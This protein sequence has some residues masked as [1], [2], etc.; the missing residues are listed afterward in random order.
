MTDSFDSLLRKLEPQAAD[1]RGSLREPNVRIAERS[2][3]MLA[4]IGGKIAAVSKNWSD[5]RS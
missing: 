3:T 4:K 5:T 2:T 1:R